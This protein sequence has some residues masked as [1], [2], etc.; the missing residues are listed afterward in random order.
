MTGVPAHHPVLRRPGC[1]GD[2]RSG[3]TDVKPQDR[4]VDG[5]RYAQADLA[6]SC[7][8]EREYLA[9]LLELPADADLLQPHTEPAAD[10]PRRPGITTKVVINTVHATPSRT[11]NGQ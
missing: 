6:V 4:A 8:G 7:D 1:C 9:K 3:V 5:F 11:H 10:Q 2:T